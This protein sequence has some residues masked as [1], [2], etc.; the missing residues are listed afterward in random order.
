MSLGSFCLQTCMTNYQTKVIVTI[1]SNT[2][3]T[4][5]TAADDVPP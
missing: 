2:N 1:T 3:R 5:T 4:R